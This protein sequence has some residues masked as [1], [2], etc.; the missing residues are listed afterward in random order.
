MIPI[1]L[2]LS[3][4]LS[5]RDPVELDFRTFDL[6]CI[7]GPNGAGKSSLLDAITWALFGQARR[8]DEAIINNQSDTADV[9]LIFAYEGNVYR[10]RRINPRGDPQ[11]LEFHIATNVQKDS[12]DISNT[13]WKPL[14]ERTLR[15]TQNRIA[16]TLLLDY[17]TFVNAAFFLQGKADQFTQQRPADRKRI[18]SN[19]LGLEVW[20]TYRKRAFE[21]RRG[22]EEDIINL[23]GRLKEIRDELAEEEPRRKRLKELEGELKRLSKARQ[24]Q[25]RV[26]DNMRKVVAA[27]EKQEEFVNSLTRQ[28]ETLER[29]MNELGIR[30]EARQKERESY[31]QTAARAREIR[32]AYQ[33]WKDARVELERWEKVAAQFRE[34]E[35]KRQAPLNVINTERAR[36][37]TELKTLLQENEKVNNLVAELRSVEERLKDEGKALQATQAKLSRR[38]V[39]EK[40]LQTIKDQQSE[41]RAENPRL[42]AEM[43]ELKKRIDR[44]ESVE[45]AACPLCGQPLNEE[46]REQLIQELNTLGKEKGDRYRAN[47]KLLEGLE[48]QLEEVSLRIAE[49]SQVDTELQEQTKTYSRLTE[50]VEQIERVVNAWEEKGRP[51][52]ED[53]QKDLTGETFAQEA[54]AQLASVDEELKAIGYDAQVHDSARQAEAELRQAEE[55]LREL[56][57]AEATLAPLEREIAD[58]QSQIESQGATLQGL[59]AEHTKASASLAVAR[60]EAPDVEQAERKLLDVQEQENLIRLEVGAAQQQV[61][62]LKGLKGRQK[63]LTAQRQELALKVDRYQV[64]EKAFGKNGVPALLIEQALPQI[65][66]KAN[67]IL[68][69]LSLGSMSVQFVT[70]R[71]Y[72]DRKRDDLRETLDIRISDSAGVRDYEM[73]SGGEAFR[74]NF[75]IRLALSEVLARRAG[76]RLQTLVIDEGFGSQ[77]AIGRQRLVEAINLIKPDFAKILVITHIDELKDVF[78]TRIEVEK[79][80]RGSVVRVV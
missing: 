40:E 68:D 10:L 36:L 17:E 44:L 41:A 30:L 2:S 19:I 57:K 20:E 73:Y 75:A 33:S 29:A 34:G 51:R 76:A 72:K 12:L 15:D 1:R 65:E 4:F 23:D 42:K 43:E 31:T 38:A 39:L 52:L 7:S 53:I 58:V 46:D 80:T 11:I 6:A 74:V 32:T 59:L 63:E 78:P 64:L 67:E 5:Y 3:G 13:T 66:M 55:G 69:R 21:R 48:T 54:R 50:K 16:E 28:I 9:E 71:A 70:Q 35:R 60:A 27:V 45:G 8:R 56:E 37:E 77:D 14:T 24:D 18:L 49:F 79:T 22:V 62:V 26:V 47:E 61:D 25:E